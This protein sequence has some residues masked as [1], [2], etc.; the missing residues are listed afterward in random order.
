MD[1][2]QLWHDSAAPPTNPHPS[3]KLVKATGFDPSMTRWQK[4]FKSVV[5]SLGRS[6]QKK[7]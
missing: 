7:T 3:H 1:E 6:G 5:G 2:P 4:S